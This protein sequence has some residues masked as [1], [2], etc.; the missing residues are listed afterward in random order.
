MTTTKTDARI[1]LTDYASYNNGSQ[2][3]FGHW[4]DLADFNDAD[5]FSEYISNHF[6][7][8]DEKSP[9]DE[10]TKREETMFTGFEGFP[11][12]LYS[13]SL[14][15]DDLQKI[16]NYIDLK[17]PDEDNFK[18]W[19]QLHNEFCQEHKSGDGEIHENDNEFFD[20]FF[21]KPQDAVRASFYGDYRF[22]DDYVKF[23]GYGNLESFD[24]HRLDSAIDQNEI[25]NWKLENL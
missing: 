23:D 1:F 7:E 18:D 11:N 21:T 19:I 15:G 5:E 13:E 6:K 2:F 24:K 4:V 8:C 9:I 16:F 25:I 14:S 20:M 10:H 22:M 12:S 17:F 3:E